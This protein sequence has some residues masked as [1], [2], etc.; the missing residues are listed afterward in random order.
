MRAIIQRVASASVTGELICLSLY[1]KF[2]LKVI[3][4]NSE[5][6]SQISRGLMVLVGIGAGLHFTHSA[7]LGSIYQFNIF[8]DR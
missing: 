7:M 4:V 3:S 8:Q 2:C 5:V 1:P 6:I